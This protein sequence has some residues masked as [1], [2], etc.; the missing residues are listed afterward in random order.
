MKVH[1]RKR[2]LLQ[3][4]FLIHCLLFSRLPAFSQEATLMGRL[5]DAKTNEAILGAN[6]WVVGSTLGTASDLSGNFQLSLPPGTYS[7]SITA[8]GYKD[9]LIES[10]T[11]PANELVNA[12]IRLH[13][14][15]IQLA[16]VVVEA[17]G[18]LSNRNMLL[19]ARRRASTA[20]EQIGAQELSEKGISNVAIGL[21]RVPGIA[22]TSRGIFVRGLG[23]RYNNVYLNSLPLPSANPDRKVLELD[24]LPTTV[25]RNISVSKVYTVDQFGDISGASIDVFSKD[26]VQEDFVSFEAGVGYNSRATGNEFIL[27]RDLASNYL[28]IAG[29]RKQAPFP[30]DGT[31]FVARFPQTEQAP[32]FSGFDPDHF[33]APLDQSWSAQFGK[34]IKK[35][36]NSWGLIFGTSYKNR[37]RQDR[38]TNSVLDAVQVPT[39]NFLRQRYSFETNLSSLLGLSFERDKRHRINLNYLLVNNGDNQ[40]IVSQGSTIDF[41]NLRRLRSR[42]LQKRLSALQVTAKHEIVPNRLDIQWGGSSSWAFGG[43]PDRR[44]LTFFSTPD[45]DRGAINR[46][47]AAENGRFFQEITERESSFFS[48]VAI[49]LGNSSL[50]IGHQFRDKSRATDF[51]TFTPCHRGFGYRRHR[52]VSTRCTFF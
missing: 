22:Q 34:S 50:H 37:Y 33:R 26:P 27:N 48:E 23:D 21:S 40:F 38:G 4:I 28:G 41:E 20:V 39:T 16:E 9:Y 8:I 29:Q 11:I 43:E 36:N 2:W 51:R 5:V 46:N 10:L 32:F 1:Q 12:D 7:L 44:D 30:V 18:D 25:V 45:S 3:Y 35:S 49:H 42:F 52:A 47:I 6:I 24:I 17:K 14:D 15:A 13:E 19:L 31:D